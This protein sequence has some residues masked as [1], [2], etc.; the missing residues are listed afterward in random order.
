MVQLVSMA[1]LNILI[2]FCNY[3]YTGRLGSPDGGS[4]GFGEGVAEEK[5]QGYA[6]NGRFGRDVNVN[7][8]F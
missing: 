8:L 4:G 5:K 1:R 3:V 7:V 2:K 6:V